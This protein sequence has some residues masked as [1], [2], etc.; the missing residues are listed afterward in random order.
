M[1]AGT[2][3]EREALQEGGH[4]LA[5]HV[6]ILSEMVRPGLLVRALEVRAQEMVAADGDTMAFLHYR[7]AKS[8]KPFPSG[9]CVSLNNYFVH[10]PAGVN[11]SVIADG[12]VVSIDFGIKH[13]GLYTDHAV[14]VIAGKGSPEDERLVAGTKEA[15][16]AGIAAARVGNTTGD[17]GYAVEQVANE[18]GFGFPR[19][20]CGHGVGK[21]VHEE[22]HVPN[23]GAK[24]SGTALVENLVIAIEPM[25]ALGSGDVELASDGLTYRTKD[26]SRAAHFEHTVIITKN[27]PEVLTKEQSV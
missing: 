17:I 27:G 14:T 1:V 21:K 6:R 10:G 16:T 15:L 22:P 7:A 23:F 12:D 9:L 26:G 2:E 20:L 13:A 3:K 4:R 18:Y 19:N 8:E 11:Q 24:G 5:R 25:F